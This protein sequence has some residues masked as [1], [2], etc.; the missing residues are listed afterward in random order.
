MKLAREIAGDIS[1]FEVFVDV[2]IEV[3]EAR[4]LKGLYA[5]AR[6]GLIKN[7]TGIDA[8]YEA[9]H[10]PDVHLHNLPGTDL[11][12]LVDDVMQI[13]ADRQQGHS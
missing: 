4:D 7:F 5:R 1:F 6:S 3:C 8:P 13:V 11:E 9:P 12:G 2:P 10:Q